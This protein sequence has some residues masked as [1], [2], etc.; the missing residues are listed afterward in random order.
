MK[1]FK[2][3]RKHVAGFILGF[4][5]L[6]A[7]AQNEA[8]P[9]NI[10]SKIDTMLEKKM[11]MT[12]AG[13]LAERYKIQLFSGERNKAMEALAHY[14]EEVNIWEVDMHYET[15][16]YKVWVGNYRN[17]LDAERANKEIKKEFPAAFIFKPEH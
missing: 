3:N 2:Q 17:R 1:L 14:K 10:T 5:A 6:C 12:K 16:N 11:K 9:T 8:T 4:T 13:E 15:P 7:T